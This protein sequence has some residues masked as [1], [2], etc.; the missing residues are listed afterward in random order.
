VRVDGDSTRDVE[1]HCH[2]SSALPDVAIASVNRSSHL[3]EEGTGLEASFKHVVY[4]CVCVG[5]GEELIESVKREE[6]SI[7]RPPLF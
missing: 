3:L 5:G 2:W 7:N 1:L 4:V 6:K